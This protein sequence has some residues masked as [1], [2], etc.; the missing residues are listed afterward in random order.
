MK[1]FLSIE[2]E[3][4]QGHK[5]TLEFSGNAVSQWAA[6]KKMEWLRVEIQRTGYWKV[7]QMS[8]R[9]YTINDDVRGHHVTFGKEYRG[10]MLLRSGDITR[11]IDASS[12]Q[13]FSIGG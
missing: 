4:N 13:T 1:L 8:A 3:S 6:L 7:T 2:I 5:A 11:T 9:D 10:R 12:L